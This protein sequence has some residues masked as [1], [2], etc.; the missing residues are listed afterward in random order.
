MAVYKMRDCPHCG[1]GFQP[2]ASN[3]IHCSEACSLWGR[4]DRS[5]GESACWRFL[6]PKNRK[7]Y[8]QVS[9]KGRVWMAH[10]LAWHLSNGPIPEGLLACHRCDN[11]GCV[12]PAHLFLGTAM[13][14][15]ADMISKGREDFSC[16]H[17]LEHRDKAIEALPRGEAHHRA[18]L[19]D[20][21]IRDIRADKRVA[22]LVAPE[23]GV[24]KSLITLIRAR[25]I[26]KHVP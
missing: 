20:D 16:E 1:K 25:S 22:R 3:H 9:G 24:S 23:Y 4:S 11:P 15:T 19:T 17:L 21:N 6:G 12:N 14:N 5:G 8:G 7:G 2:L 18:K 13:Q 26:W 10:R